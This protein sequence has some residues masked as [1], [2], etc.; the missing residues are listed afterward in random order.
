MSTPQTD[1]AGRGSRRRVLVLAGLGAAVLVVGLAVV[2][3]VRDDAPTSPLDAD[4]AGLANLTIRPTQCSYQPE[5]GGLVAHF[6]VRTS[7]AGLLTL[8]VKAVTDEG[9]DDLD[10]VSPH[11]VR[12]TVPFYGGRTTRQFDVV[13]PLSEAEHRDGYRKCRYDLNGS[14]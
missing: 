9:A 3:L 10:V 11:V 1:P 12:Y 14:Q 2:L 4:S 7:D 5:R 8:D 13:V 6:V